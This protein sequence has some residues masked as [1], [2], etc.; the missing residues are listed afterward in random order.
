MAAPLFEHRDHF[1]AM[2]TDVDVSIYA[3]ERP[4]AGFASVRLLFERE[5]AR[6]SR[7]RPQ[8]LL[9]RLN[10]GETVHDATFAGV[11]RLAREAFAF[12]GGLFNPMILQAL[13]AAGYDRTFAD[14]HG[15]HPRHAVV[16]NPLSAVVIDGD[17]VR[18]AGG[19]LDLGGIVK[20]WTV[21]RAV[22]LLQD[23]FP[24]VLVNAGGDM[25]TA[26]SEPGSRGWEAAVS[27]PDGATGWHGA[28]NGALATSTVLRRRWSTESGA[29]AHHLIDPRTALPA[30]SPFVQ[31]SA[32]VPETWRAECWAKAIL[33]GGHPAF[34]L[35][36]SQPIAILAVEGD[37]RTHA[38]G[39][40]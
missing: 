24:A 21:D 30:E 38:A 11:C 7:F 17:A 35:A 6:F 16:P 27:L 14:V 37:G 33:I 32:W 18:L 12:T 40:G 4:F 10:G 15:G 13:Q 9:R 1:R 19:Q 26:G 34:E 2:D 39:I 31:V 22:E 3:A 25:R 5:E 36:R 8:S 23:D 29:T 28:L 20:G